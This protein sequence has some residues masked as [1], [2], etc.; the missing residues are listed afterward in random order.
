MNKKILGALLTASVLATGVA[1]PASAQSYGGVTLG[2]GTGDNR[3]QPRDRRY[4]EYNDGLVQVICS[5]R[6]ADQLENRL[7]HEV[8][9]DEI[10][11]NDADRIHGAIDR[12]EDRQRHE[13]QE[14]DRRA[15]QDIAY[16][17]NRIAQWLESEAH[18]GW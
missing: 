14:G 4:G 7:R 8:A 9:E 10:D 13:C 12:L 18:R 2:F 16:R 15:I 3:W 5:G 17:Y 1:V 6:R 11:A